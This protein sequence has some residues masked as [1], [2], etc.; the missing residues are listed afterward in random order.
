MPLGL[1]VDQ[2]RWEDNFLV[3]SAPD[4]QIVTLPNFARQGC[5]IARQTNHAACEAKKTT[6]YKFRL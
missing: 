6:R 2:K 4:L 3:W 1:P 5:A